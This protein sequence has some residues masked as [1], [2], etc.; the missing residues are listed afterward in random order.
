MNDISIS[1]ITAASPKYLQ[2]FDLRD[3]I[4]RKPLGMSLKNDDL[5]R[6]LADSIFIAEHGDR[7]IGCVLLHQLGTDTAQL[8]AMAVSADWQGRGVGRM[9]VEELEKTGMVSGL[10]KDSAARP[11]DSYRVLHQP[12]IYPGG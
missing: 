6:D 1:T 11:Q 3:E 5:S 9:L 10:R 7:V 8:R 2:V 12:R 4:L